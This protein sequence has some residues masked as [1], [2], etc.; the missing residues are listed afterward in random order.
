MDFNKFVGK[1]IKKYR[2]LHNFSQTELGDKLQ[3]VSQTI[4]KWEN[5]ER[6]VDGETI[7][8][9]ADIF[10]VPYTVFYPPIDNSNYIDAHTNNIKIPIL[11]LIKAGIPVEAQEDII[12]YIDI[13]YEWTKNGNIYYALMIS[14]NSMFPKYKPDD[15]VIFIK[16]NDCE[17]GTDCA[18]MVNGDDATFKKVIK[19]KDGILL[20]PYNGEYE[21]KFY[22]NDEIEKLPV[23]VIG[24]AKRHIRDL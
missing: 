21:S 10:K 5:G 15:I 4:S 22:T 17:S 12:G 20:Q 18:V 13:P 23:Q 24:V 6:K 11:G 3:V 19:S 16:Q 7:R 14:G 8:E 2:E 1:Q 9:L